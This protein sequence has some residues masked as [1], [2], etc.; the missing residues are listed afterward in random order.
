MTPSRHLRSAAP[1]PHASARPGVTGNPDVPAALEAVGLGRRYRRGWA[2]RDCS[3]RIP[4]G[5]ICGLVG[6]NGAGKTTLMSLATDLLAP[7]T[8][9]IEVL[10]HPAGSPDA[11]GRIAFVGQEKALYPRFTVRETF[12]LGR[13]LNPVWDQSRA[14]AIVSAGDIP[15]TARI[16]SLSG[17]QRS[18][19]AFAL[20]LGKRPDLLLLDEPMADLD[21]LVRRQ[22]TDLLLADAAR[23]GMTVVMSSHLVSELEEACDFLLLVRS[24]TVRLAGDVDGLLASHRVLEAVA[25]PG[26]EAGLAGHTVV[27]SRRSGD[28]RKVLVRPRGKIAGDWE[29]RP[30]TLEDLVLAHLESGDAPPLLLAEARV[31]DGTSAAASAPVSTKYPAQ[32]TT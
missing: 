20:A 32:E 19:V 29:I 24:G 18:R 28:R 7:S 8:G 15:L 26:R 14:E 6:P 10:G 16:A 2:L 25:G 1:L 12:R 3:L 23:R 22:M 30:P 27:D 31:D 5:R 9:T 17:G 11:R 13:E 21:P 4:T